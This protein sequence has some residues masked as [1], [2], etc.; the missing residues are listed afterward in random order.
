MTHTTA[1][2]IVA[3]LRRDETDVPAEPRLVQSTVRLVYCDAARKWFKRR[4]LQITTIVIH[5]TKHIVIEQP[6]HYL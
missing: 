2:V 5:Q 3:A 4:V 6:V 1:S